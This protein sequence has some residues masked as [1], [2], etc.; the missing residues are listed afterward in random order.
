MRKFLSIG[1]FFALVAPACFA[2]NMSLSDTCGIDTANFLVQ[3]WNPPG[4]SATVN[5]D[6]KINFGENDIQAG[7]DLIVKFGKDNVSNWTPAQ[8]GSVIQVD[9]M[10]VIHPDF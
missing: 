4:G 2:M 6:G 8:N 10:Q 3:I 1:V 5:S 7:I 9:C